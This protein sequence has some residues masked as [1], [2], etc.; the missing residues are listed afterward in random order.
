M[1]GLNLATEKVNLATI[2]KL[3]ES[4]GGVFI[5]ID[6]NVVIFSDPQTGKRIQLFTSALRSAEDVRL[7]LKHSREVYVGFEPLGVTDRR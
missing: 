2:R 5:S 1:K 6:S 3:I 7:A 4:G